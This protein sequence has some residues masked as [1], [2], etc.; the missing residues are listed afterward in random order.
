MFCQLAY[1]VCTRRTKQS[2]HCCCTCANVCRHKL[3]ADAAWAAV[4][5]ERKS[6][7]Q[8]QAHIQNQQLASQ[9]AKHAAGEGVRAVPAMA[10]KKRLDI[11]YELQD[12][13]D[14]RYASCCRSLHT[15]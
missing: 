8:R 9:H 7:A 15:K 13:V 4:L 14:R 2:I 5:E 11:L 3:E 10:G 12:V 6:D 1:A